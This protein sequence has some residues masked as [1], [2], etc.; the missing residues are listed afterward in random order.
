[1]RIRFQY[2]AVLFAAIVAI[3]SSIAAAAVPTKD[4]GLNLLPWP[5]V[6]DLADGPL[7]LTAKTRIVATDPALLPLAKIVSEELRDITGVTFA[8]VEGSAAAGDIE[9]KI[10]PALRADA[11]ILTSRDGK[12]VRVR[13]YAYT[14]AVTDRVT[15]TGWDYRAASEGTAT[16]LQAVKKDGNTVS[17]PRLTIKDW[18]NADF[19]GAMV[20]VARQ[21]IPIDAL[22]QS[23]IACRLYK[24]RY[25][26]LH[27]S[28][29]QAW[30]FP[31]TAYP[32]L[33][34]TNSAAHGGI[35]PRVY[36]LQDLKDLVAFADARGVTIVPEFET[37]GHSGAIRTSAPEIFDSI[38]PATGKLRGLALMNMVNP[39][40]YEALDT[41]IGEAS[42]VFKSSPYFHIGCDE[43]NWGAIDRAPEVV[44]YM[45]EH[46]LD[47]G[48]LFRQHVLKMNEIVK[49][50]GKRTII[51]EGGANEVS[52]E[53]ICMTWDGG[54]RNAERLVA[55][56]FTT[57]TVPWTLGV[58]LQDWNMYICNGSVLKP[59]DSVIGAELVMWEMSEQSLIQRP[60]YLRSRLPERTERTWN[61][62]TTF[63]LD[64]LAKRTAHTDHLL[65]QLMLPVQI[66][67]D[68]LD[69]NTVDESV[70]FST[71]TVSLENLIGRGS[72][73]YT[74]DGTVPTAQSP[75]YTAP[76]KF[77][78]TTRL[79]AGLFDESGK[80]FSFVSE[81][82][83]QKVNYENNLTTGK[84]VTGSPGTVAQY[85]AE[86]AV[87]G[88]PDT[89]WWAGPSPQWLQVDLEKVYTIDRIDVFPYYDGKRYYQYTVDVSQDGKT[90]TQ[91]VDMSANTKI[92]TEN[93]DPHDIKP[94]PVRYVRVNMLKNSANEG[95]HIGE[96]RVYEP[97][98]HPGK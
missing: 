66:N 87:D 41:L 97:G 60:F 14:L 40:M 38:D 15:I 24:Y 19:M 88:R 71:L 52:K 16:L 96:V 85:K 90:W 75:Q 30:T 54:T 18:P 33:G 56:G 13:D 12:F 20:D 29:D 34:S 17:V 76:L 80:L 48:G 35:P 50:H 65:G 39:K 21:D 4:S 59:T 10:D 55:D 44:A 53:I 58:P 84:P 79:K 46:K 25:L 73:H 70:F 57:I 6:I 3:S 93:G 8:S 72:I 95:V 83:W 89:A 81:G 22:K 5:H 27:M 2:L 78:T 69:K 23:V 28:D 32:Q 45:K 7:T 11:D 67:V 68:G 92:A 37:P 77:T 51:W 91:V 63:T 47:H 26:H 74:L 36:K 86:N 1:M 43:T 82:N 9:L 61:P 64:D 49:K 98:K 62:A 94:Q 42:D 31:S